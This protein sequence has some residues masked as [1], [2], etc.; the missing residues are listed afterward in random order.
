MRARRI[1]SF[2]G[3]VRN[4]SAP[5]SSA[6]RRL[7]RSFEAVM[8]TMGMCLVSGLAR[9]LRQTSIPDMSGRTRSSRISLGRSACARISP[10]APEAARTVS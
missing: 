8:M 10:S 9:S 3:L 1:T 2:R 5:A 7:S 6:L 4:S